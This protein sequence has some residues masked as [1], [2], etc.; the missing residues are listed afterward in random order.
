MATTFATRKLCLSLGQLWNAGTFLMEICFL[1]ML[2]APVSVIVS[3]LMVV[4]KDPFGQAQDAA[5]KRTTILRKWQLWCRHFLTK[6]EFP[7]RALSI[8]I[9]KCQLVPSV[10]S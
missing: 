8:C 9:Q 3:Q 4:K 10:A 6:S 2:P 1:R 5:Q 7:M